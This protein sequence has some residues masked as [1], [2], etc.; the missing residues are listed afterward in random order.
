MNH[1][2]KLGVFCLLASSLAACSSSQS[3]KE[4]NYRQSEIT[5]TLEVPPDLI[6]SSS[7]TN[8]A[9]PGSTVGTLENTGRYVETGNQNIEPKTLPLIDDIK[10][11]GQGDLVWLEVGQPAEKVYPKLRS[12]WLEQGFRL[13]MDEPALGIMKTEWLQARSG[14]ESSSFVSSML[15]SLRGADFK[16]QYTTRLERSAD[17][18]FT[19]IYVAHRSQE[20]IIAEDKGKVL[21]TARN[22]G[23]QLGPVDADKEYEMLARMMIFLGAQQQSI[24]EQVEQRALLSRQAQI[25]YDDDEEEFY[26]KVASGFE[27]TWNRLVHQFDRQDIDILDSEKNSNDGVLTINPQQLSQDIRESYQGEQA[28]KISLVGSSQTSLTRIVVLNRQNVTSKSERAKSL[29]QFLQEQLK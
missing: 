26:L 4:L 6:R 3:V 8:L 13:Q 11:K 25:E 28:L 21:A 18:S 20:F 23:W 29:L 27:Q 19:R 15:E 14:E 12:F 2:N 22:K 9:L 1:L 17:N 10:I 16:D 5:P 24:K 7:N